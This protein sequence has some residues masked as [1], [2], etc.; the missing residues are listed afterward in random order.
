THK[1]IIYNRHEG[2]ISVCCPADEAIA[3]MSCGGFW[4]RRPRGFME[5]Q[6]EWQIARGIDPDVAKRYAHAMKFGGC[7]TAEALE[8][9]RDRDCA[10]HGTAIELW[11]IDDI[12]TDRWFRNAWRR[13]HN[14]GPIYIDLNQAMPIQFERARTAVSKENKRREVSFD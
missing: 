10:P 5:T 1:R 11:D 13:S 8:I 7:T 4:S 9:I 3:W 14:G 2:G 6:I 12:P